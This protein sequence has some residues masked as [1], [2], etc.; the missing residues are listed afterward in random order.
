MSQVPPSRG[1]T[2]GTKPFRLL[3]LS[4]ELVLRVLDFAVIR[5]TKN[6]PLHI[7]LDGKEPESAVADLYRETSYDSHVLVIPEVT[8]TCRMLRTEGWKK[9]TQGNTFKIETTIS[10]FAHL[11]MWGAN[12]DRQALGTRPILMYW[13][14]DES[15]TTSTL[16]WGDWMNEVNY[17][18]DEFLL[19][20]DLKCSILTCNGKILL[21]TRASCECYFLCFNQGNN[22]KDKDQTWVEWKE[23]GRL[24]FD[25]GTLDW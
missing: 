15:S 4:P 10:G 24:P 9:F 16:Q 11:L 5:S 6:N 14:R 1:A 21:E 7:Y 22:Q 23:A 25:I 12:I 19:S 17:F 13:A 3:D 18:I 8:R 2:S 20:S